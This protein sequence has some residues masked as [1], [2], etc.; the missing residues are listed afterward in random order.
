MPDVFHLFKWFRGRLVFFSDATICDETPSLNN[1]MSDL[2]AKIN[3][4]LERLET[5]ELLRWTR[6]SAVFL[7]LGENWELKKIKISANI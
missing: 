7:Q 5:A 1:G 6:M 3:G 4:I 2:N